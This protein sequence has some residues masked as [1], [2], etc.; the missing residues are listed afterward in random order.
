MHNIVDKITEVN[1]RIEKAALIANR[2]S[3]DITLLAVSK[4]QPDQ[5]LLE[6]YSAGL[7]HFGENYV[8]EAI[9]KIERLHLKQ[10]IWHFIGPIQSNKTKVIAEHFHWVHSVDRL[11]IAQRLNDQRNPARGPL[12]ICL[13]INIDNEANK[14]GINIEHASELALQMTTLHNLRLRGLMTIPQNSV[15][16]AQSCDAFN[17]MQTLFQQLKTHQ[18]LAHMDTLSMGMSTDME[19]AI[20]QGSTIVRVGT[21][22]FGPRSGP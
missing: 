3:Q 21:A 1:T 10:A 5:H 18:P 4:R 7:R 17:R 12:N 14:A 13:Q 2:N 9:A 6:A 11:K 16:P 8:Q 15:T 19:P 20:S 22:L